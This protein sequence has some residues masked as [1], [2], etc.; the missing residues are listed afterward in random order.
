MITAHQP[1]RAQ[2]QHTFVCLGAGFVDEPQI[3]ARMLVAE[4]QIW[5]RLALGMWPK[6]DG[7]ALRGP[8]RIQDFG[9]REGPPDLVE[10]SGAR[11]RRS[12]PQVLHRRKVGVCHRF[13]IIEHHGDHR[14]HGGEPG[15]A[16][17]VNCFGIGLHLETRHENHTRV[18]REDQMRER[19]RVH[20]VERRRNQDLLVFKAGR[21]KPH[22]DDPALRVMG[23]HDAF[24]SACRPGGIEKCRGLGFVGRNGLERSGIHKGAE[25][26]RVV[27]VERVHIVGQQRAMLDIA[28]HETSAAIFEDVIDGMARQA[29]I[30]RDGH[31]AGAH[32]AEMNG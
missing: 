3:D 16:E 4:R 12:Y 21:S 11:R 23:E 7:A 32:D 24:W 29:K 14:R 6:D 15:A 31:K 17:T 18:R 2:L 10:Q 9:V 8:I 30:D 5:R 13:S 27:E 1:G 25:L 19:E 22:L 26:L 20:V 28:E